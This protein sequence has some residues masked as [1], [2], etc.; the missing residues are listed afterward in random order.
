MST[1]EA[2]TEYNQLARYIF[3]DKK[4]AFQDG[5]FK[6]TRLEKAIKEIVERYAG[7]DNS[8][9][10]DLRGDSVCKM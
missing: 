7:D 3:G 6:A 2:L 9:M 8:D 5:A 10:L 1:T 4:W